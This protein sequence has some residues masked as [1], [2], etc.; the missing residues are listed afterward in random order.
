M[1]SV[2]RA[3]RSMGSVC[4]LVSGSTS[5]SLARAAEH[6]IVSA[7]RGARARWRPF[8]VA[9]FCCIAF[10]SAV[11]SAFAAAS[12][13]DSFRT[14]PGRGLLPGRHE[15]EAADAFCRPFVTVPRCLYEGGRQ[16]S[17]SPGCRWPGT[18][19]PAILVSA[20]GTVC[21]VQANR[22]ADTGADARV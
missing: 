7:G 11:S 5:R 10:G 9:A 8:V 17:R 19:S 18:A 2:G 4:R 15:P 13:I 20:Q 16:I 3:A 12:T 1:V 14:N 22:C 6:V 21:L